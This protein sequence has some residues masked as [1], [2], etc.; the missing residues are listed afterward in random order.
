MHISGHWS[1]SKDSLELALLSLRVVQAL[2]PLALQDLGAPSSSQEKKIHMVSFKGSILQGL[3]KMVSTKS[4]YE[5]SQEPLP[6]SD[7][8]SYSSLILSEGFI[9]SVKRG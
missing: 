1:K 9:P 2:T 8:R 7:N 3:T 5:Y 6:Q 4:N